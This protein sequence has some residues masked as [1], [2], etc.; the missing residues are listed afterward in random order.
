MKLTLMLMGGSALL[1]VGLLGIYFNS[2][3]D[4][5]N[6]TFNILE[7]SKVHISDRSPAV[8]LPDD[9]YRIWRAWARFSLSIPGHLTD[10]LPLLLLFR[11]FMQVC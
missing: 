11:C 3:A 10:M 9:F 7:I 8:F 4:G 1:L 2:N 6:L 5:G